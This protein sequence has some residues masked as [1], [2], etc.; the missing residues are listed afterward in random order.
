MIRVNCPACGREF[1]FADVL[2]GL[3]AVCKNCGHR[4]PVPAPGPK[5][6]PAGEAIQPAPGVTPSPPAPAAPPRLPEAGPAGSSAVASTPPPDW[7]IAQARALPRAEDRGPTSV[8]RLVAQGLSPD[9]ATD[10]VEKVLEERIR[11]QVE[12][13]A[14]AE[15]RRRRH[16]L[17]SGLTAGACVL[18]AYGFFGTWSACQTG[19]QVLLPLACIWFADEMGGYAS[20]YSLAEAVPGLVIRWCGWFLLAVLAIRVVWLGIALSTML[21]L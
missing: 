8:Q 15:R 3:T 19:L 5:A 10:V 9:A 14:Q 4:I 7:T 6:P 12:P 20:K 11:Q 2:A 21:S 1:E 13:L 17:A 18:L 16:R